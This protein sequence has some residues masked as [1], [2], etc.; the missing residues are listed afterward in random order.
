[1][2]EYFGAMRDETYAFIAS[3]GTGRTDPI[4]AS[5]LDG[6]RVLLVS[7]A[8]DESAATGEIVHLRAGT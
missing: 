1:M 8:I 2:R 6:Q 3:V 5:G 4:L 7:R